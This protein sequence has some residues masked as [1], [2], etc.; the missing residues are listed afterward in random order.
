MM[1]GFR[2]HLPERSI[3]MAVSPGNTRSNQDNWFLPATVRS[4]GPNVS[5]SVNTC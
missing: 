5:D 2:S 4:T 1:A 3:C